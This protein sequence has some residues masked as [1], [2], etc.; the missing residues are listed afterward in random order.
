[1]CASV[2]TILAYRFDAKTSLAADQ[3][4][5]KARGQLIEQIVSNLYSARHET[6]MNFV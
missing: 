6:P 5:T 2:Y 3:S 4:I 1:M